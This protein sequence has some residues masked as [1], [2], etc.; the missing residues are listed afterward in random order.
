MQTV[1]GCMPSRPVRASKRC[2]VRRIAG[3]VKLLRERMPSTRILL[4][5]ILPRHKMN[6]RGTLYWPMFYT[7]VRWHSICIA[8]SHRARY[9][10]GT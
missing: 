5:G 6:H 3:I 7:E 1:C 4:M 8:A 2:C 9:A 10:V